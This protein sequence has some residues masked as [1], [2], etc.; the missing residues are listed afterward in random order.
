M[1]RFRLKIW[2]IYSRW[3]VL[4]WCANDSLV[5]NLNFATVRPKK[6]GKS[7]TNGQKYWKFHRFHI[8]KILVKIMDFQGQKLAFSKLEFSSYE[9]E[10]LWPWRTLKFTRSYGTKICESVPCTLKNTSTKFHVI[11]SLKKSATV[12][13]KRPLLRRQK[14]E[15]WKGQFLTLEIHDF[16]QNFQNMKPVKFSVF[17]TVGGR[18]S[19]FF[20]SDSGK[21]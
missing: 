3:K 19:T 10:S 16:N 6:G 13:S 4:L 2:Y 14:F 17:L 18:F 20:R 8:L 5:L 7:T 21:I 1:Y 9:M 15:F 12:K 11:W